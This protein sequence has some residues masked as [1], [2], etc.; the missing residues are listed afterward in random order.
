MSFGGALFETIIMVGVR[1]AGSLD[2]VDRASPS[3]RQI[4]GFFHPP[5]EMIIRI[6]GKTKARGFIS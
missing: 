1:P 5:S 3:R 6:K 2:T 4:P